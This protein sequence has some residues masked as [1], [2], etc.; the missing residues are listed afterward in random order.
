MKPTLT[1]LSS[2]DEA[3]G[4]VLRAV[5]GNLWHIDALVRDCIRRLLTLLDDLHRID[6][7]GAR[8]NRDA[9]LVSIKDALGDLEL[10]LTPPPCKKEANRPAVGSRR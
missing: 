9:V 4:A 6:T 7:H 1:R 8:G 3:E 5:S 2:Y 10:L